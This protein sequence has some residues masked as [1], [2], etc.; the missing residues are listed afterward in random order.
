M[1]TR[2]MGGTVRVT[3]VLLTANDATAARRLAAREIGSQLD[4]HLVRSSS[5]ARHL[6]TTAPGH[7]RRVATDDRT[8]AG[9]ATEIIAAAGWAAPAD[10]LYKP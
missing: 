5:M 8:V 10:D 2:A 9:I 7:V 1:I 6:E 3:A 4:A